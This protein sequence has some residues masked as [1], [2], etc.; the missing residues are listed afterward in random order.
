MSSIHLVFCRPLFLLP[1][2][3]PSIGVFSNESALHIKWPKYWSFSFSIS[4]SNEYPRF[5][6]FRIEWFGV[7]FLPS[8]DVY[9]RSF[10]YTFYTLIK[11]YHTHTHTH[12]YTHRIEWFGLLQSSSS[13]GGCWR[14]DGVMRETH[15]SRGFPGF[16]NSSNVLTDNWTTSSLK[17][18][19]AEWTCPW[20]GGSLTSMSSQ[21][22]FHSVDCIRPCL[23]HWKLQ[24]KI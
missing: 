3:F 17:C 22:A 24:Q 10:L 21:R 6:S 18:I 14:H 13:F 12:T 7:F 19:R 20:A 4:P 9:V 5:I 11:L 15:P 8:S 1:S 16:M 23:W 2:I